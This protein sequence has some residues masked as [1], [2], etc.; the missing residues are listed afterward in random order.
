MVRKAIVG[1]PIRLLTVCGAAAWAGIK[2]G[3]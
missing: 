2:R 1:T 3:Y